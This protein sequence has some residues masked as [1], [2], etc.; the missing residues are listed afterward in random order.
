MSNHR[1]SEPRRLDSN[2]TL[3]TCQ[4]CGI[5]RRS[6]H[7]PAND[8]PHWTEYETAAGKRIGEIGKTPQCHGGRR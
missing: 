1:W 8:P 2:N 5:V 4:H 6:R 7:E 3:R